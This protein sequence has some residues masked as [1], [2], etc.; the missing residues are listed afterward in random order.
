[1]VCG[2]WGRTNMVLGKNVKKGDDPVQFVCASC[3]MPR[4][5]ESRSLGWE[6][7]FGRICD[8]RPNTFSS[9]ITNKYRKG[10]M[11]STLERELN[12]LEIAA[13]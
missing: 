11:Q 4:P 2:K 13:V 12:A 3:A 1:M 7:K 8:L 6:R 10:K 5:T 9:P